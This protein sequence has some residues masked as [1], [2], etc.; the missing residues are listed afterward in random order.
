[1]MNRVLYKHKAR[2]VNKIFQNCQQFLSSSWCKT[3]VCNWKLLQNLWIINILIKRGIE[4]L[5]FNSFGLLFH[6]FIFRDTIKDFDVP[7]GGSFWK[8]HNSTH[9]IWHRKLIKNNP[10][11]YNGLNGGNSARDTFEKREMV[12]RWHK[13]SK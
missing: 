12:H 6:H 10:A 8:R 4:F 11:P 13:D 9:I 7:E 2:R 1:M 5:F 3:L